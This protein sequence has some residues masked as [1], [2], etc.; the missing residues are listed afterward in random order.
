[1][2]VTKRKFILRVLACVCVCSWLQS[3]CTKQPVTW[4]AWAPVRHISPP[5][6]PLSSRLSIHPSFTL[7]ISRF[8]IRSLSHEAHLLFFHLLFLSLFPSL[9]RRSGVTLAN[10]PD[11]GK[12]GTWQRKKKFMKYWS[13]KKCSRY[14]Q[15]IVLSRR[16][17][18]EHDMC[19]KS[20]QT[21]DG[22]NWILC[23]NVKTGSLYCCC[24]RE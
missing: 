4:Q 8:V 22:F 11:D 14:F 6:L 1:M 5:S 18:K 3:V 24:M 10:V 13:K 21:L 16:C 15:N 2:R 12:D 19:S 23:R 20:S 9:N 7:F 17:H